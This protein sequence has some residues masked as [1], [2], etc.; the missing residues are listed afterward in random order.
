MEHPISMQI[1]TPVQKLKHDAFHGGR[2]DRM[3]SRLSVMMDDL[4]QIVLG[5]F[6]HHEDAFVFEDDFDEADDIHMT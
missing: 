4:Q 6:K 5:I 3:S 1:L 2:R